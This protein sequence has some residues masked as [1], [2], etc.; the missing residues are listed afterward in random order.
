MKNDKFILR[1]LTKHEEDLNE[2]VDHT[3]AS[4][5][6]VVCLAWCNRFPSLLITL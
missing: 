6:P 4:H 3:R 1:Y 2:I 5:P